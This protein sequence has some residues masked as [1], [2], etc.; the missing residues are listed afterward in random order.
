[1]TASVETPPLA[2]GI[3]P[4]RKPFPR[5]AGNTPACAGNTR[6][7]LREVFFKEKH[8]RLR[9]EYVLDRYIP[10]QAIETPPLARG[11][12]PAPRPVLPS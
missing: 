4:L 3:P 12:P 9:G 8:P 10:G 2:R 6:S 5:L 11:I 1:M 7:G